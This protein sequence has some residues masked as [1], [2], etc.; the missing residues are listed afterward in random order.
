[1]SIP[2]DLNEKLGTLQKRAA[3]MGVVALAASVAGA[4]AA[5]Q[6]FFRSY[7]IGYLL[8]TGIALGALALLMI[9][10]IIS[11]EWGYIGRRAF[12]AATRTLPVLLI[13]FIPL[14]LGLSE[15]YEWAVPEHVAGDELL[16][17]KAAYLNVT[18]FLI[19]TVIYFAIWIGLAFQLNRWSKAQDRG[20]PAD[21]RRFQLVSGIGLLLFGLTVTFA[22]VD[23]VMSLE[24]HWFSTIYGMQFVIGIVLSA[25]AFMVPV[26]VLLSKYEPMSRHIERKHYHDFGNLMLAFVLLWAYLAFSQYLI[27]WSGNLPEEIPWYLNRMQGGWQ[28]IGL[29]LVVFHFAV[30]FFLL[31]SRATKRSA[32]ILSRVA[33]AILVLRLV[34]LIWLVEPAFTSSLRVHWMDVAA[35]IGIGGVWLAIFTRQL[36]ALPLLPVND[37]RFA[38]TPETKEALEHGAG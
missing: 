19:R 1:V 21:L 28:Y 17:H 37:P 6:Q 24:P 31:L 35:P 33:V 8:I 10:H 4:F 15:L 23:W 14:A 29:L 7:L 27:T 34:D 13:A 30:P 25:L 5:P 22:S 2:Q 26:L 11:G 16:E 9:Q 3:V 20:E 32:R 36:K 18:F 12:E 38:G